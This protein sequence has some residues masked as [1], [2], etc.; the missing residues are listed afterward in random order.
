[1]ITYSDYSE[2]T[3]LPLLVSGDKVAFKWLYLT[4]YPRI[5]SY[6]LKFARSPELAEDIAQD[7]FLK[8]HSLVGFLLSLVERRLTG[9]E[10]ILL[11]SSGLRSGIACYAQ[12]HFVYNIRIAYMQLMCVIGLKI[13]SMHATGRQLPRIG[14]LVISVSWLFFDSSKAFSG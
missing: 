2:E 14:L 5:Y 13:I 12:G 8:K 11:R 7:V 9:A 1:M 6:A 4:Y 10:R 3:V